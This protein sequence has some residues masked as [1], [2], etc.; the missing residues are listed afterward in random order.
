MNREY[1]A[2]KGPALLCSSVVPKPRTESLALHGLLPLYPYSPGP[3]EP[4]R[5]GDQ[6]FLQ[7]NFSPTG[8]L[9]L[10]DPISLGFESLAL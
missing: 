10:Q 2:I 5:H 9:E 1:I 8:N 7:G 4:T 6:L 3:Q